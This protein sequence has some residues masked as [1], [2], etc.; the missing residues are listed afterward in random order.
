MF[1]ITVEIRWL[2]PW[3]TTSERIPS[4]IHPTLINNLLSADQKDVILNSKSAEA[5]Q[6]R[7]EVLMK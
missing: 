4:F 6:R 3:N 5:M 1:K 2:G 7:F